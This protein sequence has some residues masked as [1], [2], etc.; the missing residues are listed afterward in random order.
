[1]RLKGSCE[2]MRNYIKNHVEKYAMIITENPC[3]Y[4]F[5]RKKQPRRGV[6]N[7]S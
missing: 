7:D 2:I 3:Y 5:A 6:R 1:M 4:D